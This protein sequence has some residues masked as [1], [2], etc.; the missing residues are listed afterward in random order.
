MTARRQPS[1]LVAAA[2]ALFLPACISIQADGV[3]VVTPDEARAKGIEQARKTEF[4]AWPSRPGEVIHP[5]AGNKDTVVQRVVEPKNP[6][7][8]NVQV[9]AQPG[10]FPVGPSQP[11]PPVEP[12]LFAA[13]RA[14]AD[15]QPDRAIEILKAL[16]KPN[17][18]FVLALL[19]ILVRGATADLVSD[20]AALAALVEQLQIAAARLEPRAA[21]R[22]ENALFCRYVEGFGRYIPWPDGHP[23]HPYDR[24]QLYLEVRNLVS[25]PSTGPKG[26][27]YLTYALV[28]VEVRDAHGARVKLP[29]PE[30][31]RRLV[32]TVQYEAKRYTRGPIN[33][34]H[35]YYSF[36]VPTTPGVYT[37]TVEL[38]D[39]AGRRSVK[40]GPIQF[41]VAGP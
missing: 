17:Q 28:R 5:N 23:Y 7:D 10:Q 24:A 22:I 15:N 6:P 29:D 39:P 19:P 38:R 21:L 27:T 4:A 30:D 9:A 3:P 36:P 16:D 34:F 1:L 32:E 33:D 8:A 20:P 14:F 31:G 41:L 11:A 35:V 26:E 13:V 12:P 18:E 40:T 25:Q 37:A 2:A